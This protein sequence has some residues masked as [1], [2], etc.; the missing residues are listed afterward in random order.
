MVLYQA[1]HGEYNYAVPASSAKRTGSH[2]QSQLQDEG[3]YQRAL[4]LGLKSVP[5][6]LQTG[7]LDPEARK[8]SFI[9]LPNFYCLSYCSDVQTLNLICRKYSQWKLHFKY[10]I[11]KHNQNS[12]EITAMIYS[13]NSEYSTCASFENYILLMQG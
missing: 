12:L 11:D 4:Q 9:Y 2:T 1:L 3:V 5:P 7:T 6:G 13:C 8:L 10:F